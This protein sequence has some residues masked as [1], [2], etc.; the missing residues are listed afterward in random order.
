MKR[1]AN[2]EKIKKEVEA[3]SIEML[4]D[5]I[6]GEPVKIEASTSCRQFVGSWE[7]D[8]HPFWEPAINY[9]V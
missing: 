4:I 2:K 3:T 8:Q 7:D 5:E 9:E 6:Y 1:F